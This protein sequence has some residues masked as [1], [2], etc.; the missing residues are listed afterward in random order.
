MKTITTT[1]DEIRDKE[2]LR[3]T[4]MV[5]KAL[6]IYNLENG[7]KYSEL[8]LGEVLN[9]NDSCNEDNIEVIAL[10]KFSVVCFNGERIKFMKL[11][12]DDIYKLE[13]YIHDYYDIDY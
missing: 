10:T 9:L 4:G 12:R 11:N 7:G 5:G 1:I 3:L 6:A 2:A 13:D 8:P